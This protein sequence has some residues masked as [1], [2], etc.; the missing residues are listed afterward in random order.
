VDRRAFLGA[1]AGSLLATPLAAEAQSAGKIWRVGGLGNSPSSHLDDAFR[2]GLH[3][4]GWF[5]GRNILL[6]YR[7]SEGRNERL[8]ALAA[9]LVALNVDVIV[10]WAAP[11]AGA[12]KQAT[13]TISTVF[14]VHG[15][16]VGVGHVAGLARPGANMTGLSKMHPQL[17]ATLSRTLSR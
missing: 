8:A 3:D 12:A 7:Y 4:L 5:E 15:D 10:A 14:L 2:K 13:R 17:T 11:E 9:E 1:V 16:P 6:F